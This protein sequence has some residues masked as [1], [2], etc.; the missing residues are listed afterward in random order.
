MYNLL[1]ALKILGPEKL[2]A[3]LKRLMLIMKDQIDLFLDLFRPS[4]N[5]SQA[6]LVLENPNLVP[7]QA[8]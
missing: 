5:Q 6:R 2:K 7:T 8:L 1:R 4:E 3:R